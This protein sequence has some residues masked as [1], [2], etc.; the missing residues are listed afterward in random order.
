MDAPHLRAH[1]FSMSRHRR[2]YCPG[3]AFH[4]TSRLHSRAKLFDP[5]TR[6][7]IVFIL[8][9]CVR[10]S[11]CEVLAYAIMPSHVHL[12]VRQQQDPLHR[13]LQPWICR[14]ALL[15]RRQHGIVGHVF[16]R[17]FRARPCLTAAHLRD[18]IVYNHLNPVRGGLCDRAGD[19]DC[20]SHA[21]YAGTSAHQDRM[22]HIVTPALELFA[23]NRSSEATAW[24]HDYL[25]YLEYRVMCDAADGAE[26]P[27]SSRQPETHGGDDYFGLRFT[28]PST[29]PT[30]T[31]LPRPDLRDIALKVVAV[32]YADLPLSQLKGS[33]I[34][35]ARLRELRNEIIRRASRAGHS[36]SAIAAFFAMSPSRISEI[37]RAN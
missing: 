22:N 1:P 9:E 10:G 28:A 2:P 11:D 18:A 24:H 8:E 15:M 34:A 3:I 6:C 17:R 13:L 33:R 27:R 30:I 20:T 12:V 14:I 5:L 7:R 16:E 37:S 26:Q 36:G 19:A 23:A 31:S 25:R 29:N 21:V 4:I 32:Q 35:S